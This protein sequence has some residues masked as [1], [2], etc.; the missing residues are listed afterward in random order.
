LPQWHRRARL[1]ARGTSFSAPCDS[2]VVSPV[3][4]LAVVVIISIVALVVFVILIAVVVTVTT[5]SATMFL[6]GLA[7]GLALFVAQFAVAIL[8]ES[9]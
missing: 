1:C 7:S 5:S 4:V 6:E 3:A 8:I 2:I 9:C